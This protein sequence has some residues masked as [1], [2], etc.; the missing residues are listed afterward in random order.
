MCN[1]AIGYKKKL[2]AYHWSVN[3]K[4]EYAGGIFSNL[5]KKVS[6]SLSLKILSY[7]KPD[8]AILT[9]IIKR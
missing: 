4:G 2:F 5:K 8:T 9:W 1:N 7:P 6:F 3:N